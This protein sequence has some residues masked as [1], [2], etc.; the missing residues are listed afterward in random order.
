MKRQM[1][2]VLMAIVATVITTG[3]AMAQDMNRDQVRTQT[4]ENIS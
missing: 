3:A 1:K 4:R 2:Y